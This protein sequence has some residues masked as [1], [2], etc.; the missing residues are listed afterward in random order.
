MNKYH[1]VAPQVQVPPPPSY[2]E[3]SFLHTVPAA[4]VV[5]FWQSVIISGAIGL[6]SFVLQ[7]RFNAI[8]SDA[9][10]NSATGTI[11]V[12]ILTFVFLLR[13][14]FAL[15]IER[16]LDIDIPGLGEEKPK[17]QEVWIKKVSPDGR[18]QAELRTFHISDEKMLRFARGMVEG[19]PLSRRYWTKHG[20]TD[21]EYRLFQSD[22]IKFG[23]WEAAGEGSNAG[24]ILTE[25][26]IDFYEGYA[27]RYSPTPRDDD[28]EN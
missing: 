10:L 2:A 7:L 13:H 19:L 5:P 26:G 8:W 6:A 14:W 25:E 23:L 16:A 11:V 12:F 9:L 15:T 24:F 22:N 27:A 3:K 18:Y 4:V 21:G 1:S 28:L 20:F 17:P